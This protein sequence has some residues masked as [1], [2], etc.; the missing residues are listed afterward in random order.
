MF[1]AGVYKFDN[2]LTTF[3]IEIRAD[4]TWVTLDAPKALTLRELFNESNWTRI[5]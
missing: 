3:T 2:G 5:S 4:S 1:V